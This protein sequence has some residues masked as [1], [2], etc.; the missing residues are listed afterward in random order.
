MVARIDL[1][2]SGTC[3]YLAPA[4]LACRRGLT[5]LCSGTPGGEAPGRSGTPHPS[6]GAYSRQLSRAK[7]AEKREST[8]PYLVPGGE[9]PERGGPHPS[10]GAESSTS[11]ERRSHGCQNRPVPIW[12]SK[13][14]GCRGSVIA[15]PGCNQRHQRLRR[16]WARCCLEGTFD[17]TGVA[18]AQSLLLPRAW[19]TP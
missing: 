13:A 1:S 3:P 18:V 14:G 9:A 11:A 4:K 12:I 19:P 6:R 2:L 17:C 8:C 5:A 10:C 15:I 16:P 7:V